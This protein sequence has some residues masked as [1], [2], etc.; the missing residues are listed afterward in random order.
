MDADDIALPER[1]SRQIQVFA[2]YP[3]IILCGTNSVSLT[4]F[5]HVIERKAPY[6]R[7]RLITKRHFSWGEEYKPRYFADPSAVFRRCAAIACGGY[8][9]EFELGDISLWIRMLVNGTAYEIAEPLLIYRLTFSSMS[10]NPRFGRNAMRLRAKYGLAIPSNFDGDRADLVSTVRA[11]SAFW[12][13]TALIEFMS[14]QLQAGFRAVHR[15]A[16]AEPHGGKTKHIVLSLARIL[17]KTYLLKLSGTRYLRR[18]DLES[19]I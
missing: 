16:C 11:E 10:K 9:E 12:L 1:L 6:I 13:Q 17:R 14:K 7:S 2:E 15:A 3:S 19:Y 8:D 18:P 5:N 4:P